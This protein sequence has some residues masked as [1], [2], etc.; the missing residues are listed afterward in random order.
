[1]LVTGASGAVGHEIAEQAREAGWDVVG[2]SARGGN[3]TIGWKMGSEDPPSQL[4]RPWDVV[5]HAA[6]RPRW[7]LDPEEAWTS[8]VDTVYSLEQVVQP[9][10]HL[11]HISTKYAVGH[12]GDTASENLEDYRNTYEWSKAGSERVVDS[13]FDGC[14]II[15]P[16]LVVG[17]RRD[18]SIARFNGLYTILQAVVSGALPAIVGS[19]DLPQDLVSSC[20]VA[21]CTLAALDAGRPSTTQIEIL[22][23]GLDAVPSEAAI[24]MCLQ[25]VNRWRQE[26]GLSPVRAPTFVS[27]DA[28]DRFYLPFARPH[29]TN[30]QLHTI[31]LLSQFIPYLSGTGSSDITWKVESL[32]AVLPLL[33][34]RWA[35]DRPQRAGRIAQPWIGEDDER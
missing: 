29:L 22:G 10:T 33:G 17:R 32:D 13:L 16:P 35:Q 19:A 15:R 26:N 4:I 34:E 7:N 1:M 2:V 11:V 3:T 23:S 24:G 18:G 8:N 12:R 14:T 21:R 30:R 6:A 31:E 5:I 20:D 28:W 9:G 25:G 27:Q